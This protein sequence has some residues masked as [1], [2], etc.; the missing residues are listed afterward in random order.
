MELGEIAA[1]VGLAG[2]SSA[3]YR[4]TEWIKS[5]PPSSEA[6]EE[7][8]QVQL[9]R[10]EERYH[11]FRSLAMGERDEQTGEWKRDPDYRALAVIQKDNDRIA[12]LL[13][14]DLQESMQV[15]LLSMEDISRLLSREVEAIEGTAVEI[16]DD[17]TADD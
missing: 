5:L 11:R 9:A 3:H 8:R 1:G 7:Y 13:G 15:N 10:A 17:S 12:R 16:T 14:A 4:V 2:K 6:A